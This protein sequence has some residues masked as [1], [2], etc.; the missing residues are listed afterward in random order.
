M[1]VAVG[2]CTIEHYESFRLQRASCNHW[3][4]SVKVQSPPVVQGKSSR[5]VSSTSR[6]HALTNCQSSPWQQC[7]QHH[8]QK[9]GRELSS[10]VQALLNHVLTSEFNSI[11]LV[12]AVTKMLQRNSLNSDSV[13]C[14]RIIL[15]TSLALGARNDVLFMNKPWPSVESQHHSTTRNH[16]VPSSPPVFLLVTTRDTPTFKY[17]PN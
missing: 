1:A 15:K 14:C 3:K 11:A 17:K 2:Y 6:L 5:K 13:G 12:M 7:P 9:K 16:L 4:H 8:A 10:S